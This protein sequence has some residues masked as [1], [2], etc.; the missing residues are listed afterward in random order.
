MGKDNSKTAQHGSPNQG[1]WSSMGWGQVLL[2][3]SA[4]CVTL[5][6]YFTSRNLTFLLYKSPPGHQEL[7]IRYGHVGHWAASPAWLWLCSKLVGTLEESHAQSPIDA[8]L[9]QRP[10]LPG[11]SRACSPGSG[12]WTEPLCGSQP[13]PPSLCTF[14]QS[15]RSL[16]R[17][18]GNLQTFTSLP[19]RPISA[20]IG[21][22]ISI[23]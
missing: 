12:R 7:L 23:T 1:H 21:Q 6:H 18:N 9:S 3:P 2:P 17:T 4:C 5:A 19:V 16:P 15:P 22:V 8:P 10:P 14:M 13:F 11:S 20:A